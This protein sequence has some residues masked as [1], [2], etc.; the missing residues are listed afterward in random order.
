LLCP[1]GREVARRGGFWAGGKTI[2]FLFF[3]CTF[4]TLMVAGSP[5]E[6]HAWWAVDPFRLE[7]P[8]R[9]RLPEGGAFY[10][11]DIR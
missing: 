8:I 7:R 9:P 4:M 11:H 1:R 10:R 6:G 2:R 5:L 3:V